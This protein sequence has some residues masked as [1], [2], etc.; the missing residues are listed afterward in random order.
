MLAN[1]LKEKN[2]EYGVLNLFYFRKNRNFYYWIYNNYG[3]VFC[4]VI[5]YKSCLCITVYP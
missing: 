2:F 1:K 3:N 5:Y 4:T